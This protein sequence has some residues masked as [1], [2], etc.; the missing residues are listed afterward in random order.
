MRSTRGLRVGLVAVTALVAL[1]AL[2]P[3]AAADAKPCVKAGGACTA[4]AAGAAACEAGTSCVA[5][6]CRRQVAKGGSCAARA[7]TYCADG[8]ACSAGKCKAKV[9]LGGD[10]DEETEECEAPAVVRRGKCL[11]RADAGDACGA[12]VPSFCR[13]ALKCVDKMCKA[14]VPLGGSVTNGNEQ[15]CEA[16]GVVRGGKCL[17]RSDAGDACGAGVPS[18][19]RGALKCVDKMC[20]AEVPLGGSV[21]N[22]NEQACEAP[23][24]VRGGKCLKRSDAGDAC[25]AG[26]P[27]FCRGALKCVDKMCKAEVPL[28]GSVTNGNEQACEAPGVVRGGKCLKRSDAGDACGAGVPSFCRGALKCVDKTCK[29]VVPL[30]GAIR[31]GRKQACAAPGEA[32]RGKCLDRAE[33][34]EACGA[35]V[36]SFCGGDLKCVANRCKTV[37]PLGGTIRGGGGRTQAC[38][39]PGVARR[40]KCLDRAEAGE[41]CGSGVHSFCDAGHQCVAKKCKAL[42]PLGGSLTN[43][44]EQACAAPGV[45][46][47]G[48][49]LEPAD[50]GDACGSG[51]PS[52]CRGTLRCCK[53]GRCKAVVPL[54]GTIK[55]GRRQVCATSGVVRGGKCW[56]RV[57]AGKACGSKAVSL[58]K[59]PLA[60][61]RG[62][63]RRRVAAGGKCGTASLCVRGYRCLKRVCAKAVRVGGKCDRS[64]GFVCIRSKCVQGTCKKVQVSGTTKRVGLGAQCQPSKRIV[65]AGKRNKCVRGTCKTVVSL[66]GAITD[67]KKQACAKPGVPRGGQCVMRVGAGQ[68]CGAKTA[69]TC[70]APLACYRGKCRA[71]V[72]AGG[73]CG[74]T[75]PCARGYR[76]LKGVCAKAVAVGG[77]CNP[78][79]GSVCGG[80]QSRCV[81]GTCKK[82]GG[83]R[84]K[85]VG[86]GAQC[87][88]SKRIVCAGKQNKCV[89]G[90]CKTVVP[91]GGAIADVKKQA[92]AKPGAPRGGKCTVTVGYSQPCGGGRQ[93]GRSLHCVNKLCVYHLAVGSKCTASGGVPCQPGATCTAGTCQAPRRVSSYLGA[94]GA[95][96]RNQCGPGLTCDLG[97]C[98]LWLQVGEACKV[99]G[100]QCIKMSRCVGGKC[101]KY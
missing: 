20:K 10:C 28:G 65:C 24:V 48:K 58:C 4:G 101:V 87:K 81:G 9:R 57:G 26:V 69:V 64:K 6:K 61:Y 78:S 47:R 59:A 14:E 54:G 75:S 90:T 84:I 72:A 22:G 62:K 21:T 100:L 43:R 8:L 15:A 76:C 97:R 17:K 2:T 89:R 16:P 36:A 1:T 91:L 94:C 18:F 35:G 27:S 77:K 80:K 33:A 51:V 52:F 11:V 67:V 66:G 46:R 85:K 38:A 98:K 83:P 70:K 30:G 49:C 25:G 73:K 79:K 55:N 82:V 71:R 68:V 40:G 44:N 37:V 74:S 31:D 96:S 86:L 93:C 23:G 39:S 42:V 7:K 56:K 12:G 53:D 50:A 19:C 3:A 13:G 29:T 45:V 5:A 60:C 95:G 32:R 92:C 99:G 88:A 41:A 34:G 63:C